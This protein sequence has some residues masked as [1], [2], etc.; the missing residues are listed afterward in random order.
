MAETNLYEDLRDE[1]Q[2][3]DT[4]LDE[5][6][7]TIRPAVQ[8]L[9][10]QIPQLGEVIDLLVGLMNDISSEIANL[11]LGGFEDVLGDVTEFTEQ[12]SNFLTASGPL[13]GEEA[14]GPVGQIEDLLTV[15]GSLPSFDQ[16]KDEIIQLVES[17]VENLE[18]LKP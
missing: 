1:L 8:A 16:V 3:F 15:V 4:F 12:I 9:I 5:K 7:D 11:D 13:L 14:S 10:A 2:K 17:I 6:A 18:S